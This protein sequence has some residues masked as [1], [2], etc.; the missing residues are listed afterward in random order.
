MKEAVE[1]LSLFVFSLQMIFAG[2]SAGK[3]PLDS[4]SSDWFTFFLSISI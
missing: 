1:L 3:C 2:F 4:L